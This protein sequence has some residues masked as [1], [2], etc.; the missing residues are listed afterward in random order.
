MEQRAREE[1]QFRLRNYVIFFHTG[2]DT[3]LPGCA[4]HEQSTLEMITRSIK[5][6]KTAF[7]I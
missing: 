5:L 3:A 2:D 6:R 4:N 1:N 7:E